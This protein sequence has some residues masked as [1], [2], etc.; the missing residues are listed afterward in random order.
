MIMNKIGSTI[1]ES[2]NARSS[3]SDEIISNNDA[4]VMRLQLIETDRFIVINDRL[5]W[6]YLSPNGFVK[7]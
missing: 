3:L 5:Y 1:S 4:L 7:W 2:V 6:H